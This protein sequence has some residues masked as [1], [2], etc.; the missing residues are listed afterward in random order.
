MRVVTKTYTNIV[1]SYQ[2]GSDIMMVLDDVVSSKSEDDARFTEATHRTL[3]WIDR[4]IKQHANP[5]RQVHARSEEGEGERERQTDRQKEA[6][7]ILN[8]VCNCRGS[9]AQRPPY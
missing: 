5:E 8:V 3:R 6:A 2:I 9:T 4:C 1:F 7:P